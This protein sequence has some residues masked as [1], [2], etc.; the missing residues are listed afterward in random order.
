MSSGETTNLE[1]TRYTIRDSGERHE[2]PTGSRRDTRAGKGRYDLLPPFALRR[3]AQHY[4]GGA[5]KYGDRNWQK[6]QPVSRYIDSALRHIFTYMEGDRTEDTLIA[7][8]WNLLCAVETQEMVG[9]GF[10]PHEL[11]DFDLYAPGWTPDRI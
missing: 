8:A 7:A 10:L 11:D 3:L 2:F 4:E 5:R 6:G 9:R 1:G